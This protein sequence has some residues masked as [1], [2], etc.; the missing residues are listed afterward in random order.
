[1]MS[2]VPSAA[3]TLLRRRLPFVVFLLGTLAGVL[4]VTV[5]W[6]AQSF[7]DV[8]ND[9]YGYVRMARSLLRGDGFAPYGSVLNR[10]GPLYPAAIALVYL[11]TGEHAIVWQVLQAILHGLTCVLVFGVA[12]RMYNERTAIIAGVLCALHPTLLR[13]VP[14]FHVETTLTFLSTLG[15]WC[16]V[17]FLEKPNAKTGALFGVV[18]ALGALAKPVLLLTPIAFAAWWLVCDRGRSGLHRERSS[19]Q[20]SASASPWIPARWLAAAAIFAA[21][22]LVILPWTYRNYRTSGHA[23]LITT[24]AGDAFLRGYVFSRTE[25]ALLRSP[26]YTNAENASNAMFMDLCAQAG[27]VW[28]RDDVESDRILAQAAKHKLVE[29]PGA[30]VRKFA[31]QIFTFWYQ[32]TSLR[33][34]LVA[35]ISALVLWCLALVGWRRARAEGR[36]SW[37]LFL[38]ILC[39]NLS[40]AALLALG[41]Y[42]VPV[43]PALV[44]LGA[45]G[46]DT[47]LERRKRAAARG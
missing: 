4:T 30:F 24:G 47:L 31:V 10:R 44:V 45:F 7:V 26:P 27:T 15:L 38:P 11:I 35:G 36:V 25:Y 14:D 8:S 29:E 3:T 13:Y 20:R 6:R 9:P 1:M 41:R 12:R 22:G 33:N 23:V 39:L 34:S 21:M 16:S 37:P 46:F 18:A 2:E 40:L 28:Q 32:M 5:V 19:R 43:L 17:R 42:S